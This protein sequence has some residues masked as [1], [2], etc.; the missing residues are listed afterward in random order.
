MPVSL[1]VRCDSH[2]R[3]AVNVATCVKRT[4]LELLEHIARE[5][6]AGM[7]SYSRGTLTLLGGTTNDAASTAL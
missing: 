1:S 2:E 4:D 5:C 7:V 6:A 3:Y